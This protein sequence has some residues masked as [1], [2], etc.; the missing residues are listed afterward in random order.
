[1]IRTPLEATQTFLDD[2][3]RILRCFRF[4]TRFGYS[5]KPDI[6]SALSKPEVISALRQKV[7]RERIGVEWKLVL[8]NTQPDP[9][10]VIKS[11]MGHIH[12]NGIY[13]SLLAMPEHVSTTHRD[14]E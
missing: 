2:P 3:L 6:F 4:A 9:V 14:L 13:S 11:Y 5:I 7:S 12:S 1:M 8:L 10:H